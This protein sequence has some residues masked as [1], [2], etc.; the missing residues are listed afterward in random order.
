[1]RDGEV[2]EVDTVNAVFRAPRHEYTRALLAA[3]PVVTLLYFLAL[4]PKRQKDETTHSGIEAHKAAL[5]AGM[6]QRPNYFS[7]YKHPDRA[8]ERRNLVLDSMVETSAITT[9]E[10]EHAK[11]EPLRLAPPNVDASEAPYFVDLVHDQLVQRV[12]DQDLAHQ[13]LRIYTS[14]DPELQRVEALYRDSFE[15][16]VLPEPELES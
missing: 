2:V 1:M 12:N 4:H 7:P 3:V 9:T 14:L 16:L 6:I 13:S 5:I 15:G 8:L 10:A 11:A